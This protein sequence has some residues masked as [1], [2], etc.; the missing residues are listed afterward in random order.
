MRKRGRAAP[1]FAGPGSGSLTASRR[2]RP[3]RNRRVGCADHLADH[4][5]AALEDRVGHAAGVQPDRAGRVVVARDH[6]VDA[7]GRVVG[8]HDAHDA[9]CP[10]SSPRR[11]RSC[12]SPR[13]SR[14]CASGRPPMSWMPPTSCSSL[15]QLAVEHQLLPSWTC[16]RGSRRLPSG[17]MS[18]S[19]LIDCL[20]VLKLVSMPPSQRWSTYGHAGALGLLRDDLARLAL[21]ADEQDRAACWR[22]AGARTS[23]RPGTAAGVFSR[24]MMWILLRWPKMYGAILG[25]QKR[26]W[27]PKWTPASSIWRMVTDILETPVG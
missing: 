15:S 9:G 18:F 24:L 14:T 23:S 19:R 26:V 4:L 25:F 7:V 16:A 12:G 10:A 2:P 6:V 1:L 3:R 11:P 21:G 13:R 17:S 20:T 27:C 22:R 8:V 5:A